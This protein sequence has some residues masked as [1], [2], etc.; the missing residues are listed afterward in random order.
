MHSSTR[1]GFSLL[2]T[3]VAL[4]LFAGVLLSII[5]AGQVV[6]ARMYQNDLRYRSSV[7]ANSVLDSLR[8]TACGRLTS[9]QGTLG[10]LAAIWSVTAIRDIARIDLAV[11]VPQRGGAQ[12]LAKNIMT[13]LSCPEP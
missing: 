12:P 5:A 3:I 2:E 8:G 4:T 11:S 6:L 1:S 9:G 10:T 7:Y 13:L